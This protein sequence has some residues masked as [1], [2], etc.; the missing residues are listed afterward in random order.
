[1]VIHHYN[2]QWWGESDKGAATCIEMAHEKKLSVMVK[3]HLWI[4]HGGYTGAFT[5]TSE[6]DWKL[7]EDSYKEYILHYANIADGMKAELFCIGTEL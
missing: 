5:L 3:P 6:S 2:G 1:M 7:W 4:E